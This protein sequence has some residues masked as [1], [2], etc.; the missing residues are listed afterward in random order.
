MVHWAVDLLL[1]TAMLTTV[2]PLP[3]ATPVVWHDKC[4]GT[5][6]ATVST[7]LHPAVSI[8]VRITP[9][10]V[11]HSSGTFRGTQGL[12]LVNHNLSILTIVCLRV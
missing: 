9:P 11:R 12:G 4:L 1:N 2:H 5:G 8:T 3:T 7:S 10:A 6:I